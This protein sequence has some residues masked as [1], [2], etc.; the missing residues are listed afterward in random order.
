MFCDVLKSYTFFF[1]LEVGRSTVTWVYRSPSPSA[2]SYLWPVPLVQFYPSPTGAMSLISFQVPLTVSP[3]QLASFATNW[4]AVLGINNWAHLSESNRL[5]Q[6]YSITCLY[7]NQR[8][9][10]ALAKV[11]PV[12]GYRSLTLWKTVVWKLYIWNPAWRFW[13]SGSGMRPRNL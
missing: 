4:V 8:Y 11:G 6:P 9:Q 3:K 2:M 13:F 5:E 1:F 12:L 10:A 7:C